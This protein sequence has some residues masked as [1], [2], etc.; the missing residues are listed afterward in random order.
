M[1]LNRLSIHCIKDNKF[2]RN[3]TIIY[4]NQYRNNYDIHKF[5][6]Q[7][8]FNFTDKIALQRGDNH[9]ALVST[10]HERMR[11]RPT[12]TID[13]KYKKQYVMNSFNCLIDLILYHPF[14]WNIS[15]RSIKHWLINH[16]FNII[17]TVWT[18]LH[19]RLNVGVILIS[20]HLAL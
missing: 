14:S 7:R 1:R 19:L 4:W 18:E 17:S 8:R 5:R 20:W 11:K 6:Q 2:Q 13:L 3:Y 15:W 16:Q 12:E 9:V 10:T